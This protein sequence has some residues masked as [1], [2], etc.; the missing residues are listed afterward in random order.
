MEVVVPGL[1][2]CGMNE[3]LLVLLEG[4]DKLFGGSGFFSG[5]WK[6]RKE[7]WQGEREKWWQ[8]SGSHP[9]FPSHLFSA[10]LYIFPGCWLGP[11]PAQSSLRH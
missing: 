10:S 2:C 3:P 9:A 1:E 6:G 7:V 8:D 4:Q 11:K 5:V